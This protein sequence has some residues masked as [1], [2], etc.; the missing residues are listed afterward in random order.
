MAGGDRTERKMRPWETR[1]KLGMG[2][3]ASTQMGLW[4]VGGIPCTKALFHLLEKSY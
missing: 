1:K 2:W 3:E 4:W